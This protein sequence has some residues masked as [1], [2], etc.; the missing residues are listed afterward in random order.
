MLLKQLYLGKFAK[1]FLKGIVKVLF[2]DFYLFLESK[3][4][5]IS[6]CIYSKKILIFCFWEK[7]SEKL[8]DFC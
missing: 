5:T 4:P 2:P 7:K 6:F 3:I 8:A 1:I